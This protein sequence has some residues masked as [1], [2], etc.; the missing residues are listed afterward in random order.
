MPAEQTPEDASE[1]AQISPEAVR[2]FAA[3]AVPAS[4]TSEAA[5]PETVAETAAAAAGPHGAAFAAAQVAAPLAS[6]NLSTAESCAAMCPPGRPFLA[7]CAVCSPATT[8]GWLAFRH[9]P[10]CRELICL[11]SPGLFPQ[12]FLRTGFTQISAG[13]PGK[14]SSKARAV[15]SGSWCCGSF[16]Y[17]RGRSI[18]HSPISSTARRVSEPRPPS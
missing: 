15:S 11:L 7:A 16:S 9:V 18:R 5:A 14:S 13:L 6:P 17:T 1:G 4:G 12:D 10:S 8:A 2:E 3:Q